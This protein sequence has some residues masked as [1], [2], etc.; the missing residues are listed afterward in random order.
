MV[1]NDEKW[2]QIGVASRG[3][4][5]ALPHEPGVYTRTSSYIYW[6]EKTINTAQKTACPFCSSKSLQGTFIGKQLQTHYLT[7]FNCRINSFGTP[8]LGARYTCGYEFIMDTL[9]G[10]GSTK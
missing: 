6:I 4:G 8:P 1:W 5:C 9:Y 10:I 7:E 2:V 3:L